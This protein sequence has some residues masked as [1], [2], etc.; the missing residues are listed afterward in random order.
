MKR[1][2]VA[3]LAALFLVGPSNLALAWSECGHHIIAAL[4]FEMLEDSDK[5]AIVEILKEH[6]QFSKEFKIPDNVTQPNEVKQWLIGR[7]GYWPDVARDY[8]EWNRPTWHYQ[9][10]ATHV[11]GGG[12]GVKV[13]DTPGPLPGNANLDTQDLYI[14]QALELCTQV[15]KDR[16]KP[17]SERAVALCWICHLVADAHQPC[18]AGSLYTPKIFPEGDRGANSILTKQRKNMHSLWDG[19]LGSKFDWTDIRRRTVEIKSDESVLAAADAIMEKNKGM[20]TASW[21]VESR[22]AAMEAVYTK[23]V[24]GA[25]ESAM[26]NGTAME[27]IDL[28]KEYLQNAGKVSQVR[29]LVAARRLAAVLAN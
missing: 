7:A 5:Q 23:D 18:H 21:I 6:P 20:D 29:A 27:K 19:M 17:A 3:F 2:L 22:S 9:L 25:V 12:N 16:S 14:L 10:G 8:K 26:Q 28:S 15:F 13:P 1:L 24:L 11:M 4:A